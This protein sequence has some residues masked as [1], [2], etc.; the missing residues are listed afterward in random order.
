MNQANSN[1]KSKQNLVW[2]IIAILLT[3]T[4]LNSFKPIT[5]YADSTNTKGYNGTGATE[6]ES[7]GNLFW[8]GSTD[9]TAIVFYIVNGQT[10]KVLTAGDILGPNCDNSTDR[11]A[12]LVY[13][14]SDEEYF[15]CQSRIV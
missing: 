12:F 10:G 1:S 8:G 13:N 3:I 11:V 14:S 4:A 2:I 7:V 5:A 6:G 9:R 15:K